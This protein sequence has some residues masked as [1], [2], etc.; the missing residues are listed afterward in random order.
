MPVARLKPGVTLAQA[1]ADMDVIA[2]RLEQDY[3]STN[4]G[5]GDKVF[6]LRG[7]LPRRRQ[8]LYPLLGAV[9]F[10]AVDRVRKRREPDAVRAETRREE[11]I[12]HVPWC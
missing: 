10:A 5:L 3:P 8:A 6:P 4:K 2:R 12:A 9:A 11:C 7:S 1:Q